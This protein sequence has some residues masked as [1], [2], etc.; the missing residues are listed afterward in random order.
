ME[1]ASQIGLKAQK[2]WIK[3]TVIGIIS[4]KTT[5]KWLFY[6]LG[7]RTCQPF[8][9]FLEPWCVSPPE[10]AWTTQK[11]THNSYSPIIPIHQ[12]FMFI[13]HWYLPIIDKSW[14]IKFTHISN[15]PIIHIDPSLIFSKQFIFTHNSYLVILNMKK[16]W[17]FELWVNILIMGMLLNYWWTFEWCVS[18]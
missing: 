15:S 18:F 17:T 3:T 5:N 10:E 13:H 1:D 12:L 16:L 11:F 2:I 14:F 6:N 4:L 8:L 9:D 7:D